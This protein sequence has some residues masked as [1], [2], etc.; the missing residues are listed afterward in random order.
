MEIY[1]RSEHRYTLAQN[2]TWALETGAKAS[3]L[4]L[5]ALLGSSIVDGLWYFTLQSR[6]LYFGEEMRDL[7]IAAWIPGFMVV[8]GILSSTMTVVVFGELKAMRR[9]VW[10]ADIEEFMALRNE[11][12]S[13][14]VHV[15][16][17]ILASAVIGGFMGLKYHDFW[18]GTAFVGGSTFIFGFLCLMVIEMD[19]PCHGVW[20]IKNIPKGWLK[21]DP[22]AWRKSNYREAFK[23]VEDELKKIEKSSGGHVHLDVVAT[24]AAE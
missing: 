10:K 21:I 5:K 4:I 6:G 3:V 15:G 13:P 11:D 12:L 20:V 19:D 8:Y 14:M 9:A 24:T 7:I 16:L 22:K 23:R 17:F 1:R 18:S 2:L